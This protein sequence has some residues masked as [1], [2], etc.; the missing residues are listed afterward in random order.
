M[1]NSVELVGDYVAVNIDPSNQTAYLKGDFRIVAVQPSGSSFII[2]DTLGDVDTALSFESAQ[3]IAIK[4]MDLGSKHA[5]KR[6]Y[7]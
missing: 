7:G 6:T 1:T 2:H 5:F 3:D 4:R